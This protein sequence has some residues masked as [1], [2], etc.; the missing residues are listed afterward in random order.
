MTGW[1]RENFLGELLLLTVLDKNTG[2]YFCKAVLLPGVNPCSN[3]NE[4]NFL[5]PVGEKRIKG[6]SE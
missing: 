6:A 1:R 4:D 2:R 3:S 5:R